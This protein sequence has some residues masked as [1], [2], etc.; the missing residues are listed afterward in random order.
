ME[1][2]LCAAIW[3]DDQIER[4]H[5]LPKNIKTGIVVGGWRHPNCISTLAS[6]FY[7]NWKT[8]PDH[9][10]IRIKVLQNSTQGFLTTKGNFLDRQQA[11][12]MA[13]SNGQIEHLRYFTRELDSGDLY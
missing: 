2:V 8:D 11:A 6:L 1:K 4:F 3:Y 7:P 9:D 12:N 5:H 13:L 10:T